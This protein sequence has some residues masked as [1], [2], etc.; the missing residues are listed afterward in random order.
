[1]VF[2][3]MYCEAYDIH[4]FSTQVAPAAPVLAMD[5]WECG[6]CTYHNNVADNRCAVRN[7][8]SSFHLISADA[9]RSYVRVVVVVKVMVAV[10]VADM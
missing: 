2:I 7:V 4:T 1:M 6:A 10:V 8:A 9:Y 3:R 5:E